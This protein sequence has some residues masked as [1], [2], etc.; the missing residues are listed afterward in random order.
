MISGNKCFLV[1]VLFHIYATL[2]MFLCNYISPQPLMF[3]IL[4]YVLFHVNA[5]YVA[6]AGTM[7]V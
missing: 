6:L 4:V 2:Y 7:G 1:N 3:S 5:V